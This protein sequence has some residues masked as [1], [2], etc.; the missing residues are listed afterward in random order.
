MLARRPARA[1]RQ[2]RNFSA[3]RADSVESVRAPH[4]SARGAAGATLDGALARS[5]KCVLFRAVARLVCWR[6]AMA[7]GQIRPTKEKR[8]PKKEKTKASASQP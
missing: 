1:E 5:G 3:A 8:K 2:Q 4:A 7:K 6:P